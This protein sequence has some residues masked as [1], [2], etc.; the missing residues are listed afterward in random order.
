MKIAVFAQDDCASL[1]LPVLA[2]KGYEVLG[3]TTGTIAKC[4]Q[5]TQQCSELDFGCISSSDG[6]LLQI[7]VEKFQPRLLLYVPLL[8]KDSA[9][10]KLDKIPCYALQF[11][12]VHPDQPWPEFTPIWENKSESSVS[13]ATTEGAVLYSAAVNIGEDD[14]ALTLRVKHLEEGRKLLS[15]FLDHIEDLPPNPVVPESPCKKRHTKN[16]F[17]GLDRCRSVSL[18]S[19][20]GNGTKRP[21]HGGGSRH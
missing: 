9:F 6:D 5:F 20:H 10:L 3:L 16:D 17:F 18:C 21:C 13:I 11:G 8:K 12:E 15:T 1:C 14:T 2:A 19:C 4:N 7:A